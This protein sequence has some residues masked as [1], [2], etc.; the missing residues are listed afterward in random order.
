MNVSM[1]EIIIRLP[2]VLLAF[3][4]NGFAIAY[5]ATKLGDPTSRIK[6]KLT[7]SPK[8]HTDILGTL[9]F[10]SVGFG[11]AKSIEVNP[12]YFKDKQR[13]SVIT[14]LSGSIANFVFAFLACILLKIFYNANLGDFWAP[15]V[16]I[17][18]EIVE[19][20]IWLGLFCLI[21]LPPFNGFLILEQLLPTRYF[22]VLDFLQRYS[23]I[24]L[25]FLAITHIITWILGP[26]YVRLYNAM[27]YLVNIV[28]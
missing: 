28:L 22:Y 20:N 5:T 21:P 15:L 14:T 16:G 4:V 8:A 9:L 26:I 19:L 27:I 11:W 23:T 6:G 24:I 1:A 25:V 7:L 13:D 3:V 10:A 18:N 12:R 17:L 2:A